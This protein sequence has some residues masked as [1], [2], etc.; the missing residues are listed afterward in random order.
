MLLS[1]A[2][3]AIFA[4]GCD[5]K[6]PRVEVPPYDPAAIAAGAIKQYDT[7]GDGAVA[8]EELK[9]AG[10]LNDRPDTSLQLKFIDKNSDGKVTKE[11]VQA[12]AQQWIDLKTGIMSF[13][14]TVNLDGKPLEGATVKY[15]P[16]PFMGG[17]VDEA[18]G[19]TSADGAA[20][21][22]IDQAK[23]PDD[24]KGINGIRSGFYKVEI[25]HPTKSLPAHYNTATTLGQEVASD[26]AQGANTFDLKSR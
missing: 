8:G 15:I 17:V 13:H 11:E 20:V 22:A 9:K 16:E 21:I 12:R 2:L 4:S 23:L 14:C 5:R 1:V 19:K 18:S 6:P 25:T 3:L 10:C 24:Q 26:S 7:D